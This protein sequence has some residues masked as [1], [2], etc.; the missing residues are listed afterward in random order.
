[1]PMTLRLSSCPIED[2]APGMIAYAIT[3]DVLPSR[4]SVVKSLA[5]A[6][7]ERDRYAADVR[8]TGKR[9]AVFMGQ[10]A[11]CTGRKPPGFKVEASRRVHV[12]D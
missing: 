11:R 4:F 6:I 8:A 5:E 9:A 7:A 12:N 2:S 3:Q 1:M 10:A